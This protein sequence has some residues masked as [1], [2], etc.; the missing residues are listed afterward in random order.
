M[1]EGVQG[2]SVQRL[3]AINAELERLQHQIV[4]RDRV[5]RTLHSECL[6]LDKQLTQKQPAAAATEATEATPV[7]ERLTNLIVAADEA[8]ERKDARIAQLEAQ[9]TQ[10]NHR[11]RSSPQSC[12]A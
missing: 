8:A 5:I 4:L 2:G 9:L 11:M 7:S 3:E 12:I 10:S 1:L 6:V